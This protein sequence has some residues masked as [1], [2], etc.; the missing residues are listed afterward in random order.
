MLTALY[1]FY[2]LKLRITVGCPRSSRSHP[3]DRKPVVLTL[4]LPEPCGTCCCT[5]ATGS[6]DDDNF[7]LSR[8]FGGRSRNVFHDRFCHGFRSRNHEDR[9]HLGSCLGNRC[10]RCPR[11]PAT[12]PTTS[13]SCFGRRCCR[14][15]VHC[16]YFFRSRVHNR[17]VMAL[18]SSRSIDR[19]ILLPIG[20]FGCIVPRRR[21]GGIRLDRVGRDGLV[22]VVVM[23][24]HRQC[25]RMSPLDGRVDSRTSGAGA[26]CPLDSVEADL[27]PRPRLFLREVP[28]SLRCEPERDPPSSEDF[29]STGS[30]WTMMP[31][32]WQCS[33]VS[34]RPRPIRCPTSCASSARARVT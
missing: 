4:R 31:R 10:R 19:P 16:G 13:R 29:T 15:V 11:R 30:E 33:Q 14:L 32:P 3:T 2:Q 23:R 7:F 28:E 22:V 24:G 9:A 26:S 20:T 27:S 21:T 6:L 34:R 17:N 5:P 25:H 12:T 18:R 8:S 1:C